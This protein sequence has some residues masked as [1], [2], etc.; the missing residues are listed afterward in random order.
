MRDETEEE[1]EEHHREHD[2]QHHPQTL[3]R[4]PDAAP[5]RLRVVGSSESWVGVLHVDASLKTK[6]MYMYM[7]VFTTK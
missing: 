3:V 7:Y 4:Q 2:P 1:D 5:A 6:F